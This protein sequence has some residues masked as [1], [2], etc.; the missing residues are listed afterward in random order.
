MRRIK[1]YCVLESFLP[2]LNLGSENDFDETIADWARDGWHP[3]G[4]IQI[5]Y[6]D[7]S[8]ANSIEEE[9]PGRLRHDGFRIG[10]PYYARQTMVKYENLWDMVKR[11]LCI[12]K[13]SKLW[14]SNKPTE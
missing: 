9:Y 1:D 4:D 5:K 2:A 14:G 13:I 3:H 6:L 7:Q 11:L 12:G 8:I 10:D